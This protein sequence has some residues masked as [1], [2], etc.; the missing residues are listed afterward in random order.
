MVKQL[1]YRNYVGECHFSVEDGIYHGKVIGISDLV[2]F[3]GCSINELA[4]AFHCAID[5]YLELRLELDKNRL[6]T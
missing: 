6:S 2:C 5:D 4:S 1:E 3:E